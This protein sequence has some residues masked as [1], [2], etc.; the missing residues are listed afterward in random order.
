MND[1]GTTDAT[2]GVV[3]PGYDRAAEE[4][5][6]LEGETPW[7]R[8]RW[9]EKLL[10]RLP[11]GSSVLDIGCGSGLPAD[12]L[13]AKSHRITGVDV[14]AAQIALARTNVP[15]GRF[16][17][18]DIRDLHFKEGEFDAVVTF[19]TFDHIPR[20]LHASALSQVHSW[21]RPGGW[22][23]LSIEAADINDVTDDWLG[24]PMFF[25][26]Y[27]PE[28]TL[29]IVADAGFSIVESGIE[30]QTEGTDR[31]PYL[32]ILARST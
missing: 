30:E 2:G 28:I 29:S 14:S 8:I 3:G 13:I 17:H 4:Y 18:G 27:P 9:L 32:W 6:R 7:P 15:S 19:Y 21:L 12:S 24:Q 5:A 20:T 26:I 11:D 1:E 23:L 25:S 31:I 10:D 22:L 16:L